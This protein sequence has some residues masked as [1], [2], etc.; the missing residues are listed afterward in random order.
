[1]AVHFG[2][3]RSALARFAVPAN[4]EVVG[5]AGLNLVHGVEHHHSFRHLGRVIPEPATAG[6]AAP[7]L[8]GR[9]RH[10][11]ASM[12]AFSSSGIAGIGLLD[13]SI[14]PSRPLRTMRLKVAK[15]G[16]LSG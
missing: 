11:L 5:L 15:A 16:S 1:M 4:G 6:I 8:E 2:G 12:M 10:V 3:T 14:R 9:G 13:T 7:D